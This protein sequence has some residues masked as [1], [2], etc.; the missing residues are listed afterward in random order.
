MTREEAIAKAEKYHLQ[1]EVIYCMDE[2]GYSPEE[3]LDEWDL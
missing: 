2:L 1:A 3:A